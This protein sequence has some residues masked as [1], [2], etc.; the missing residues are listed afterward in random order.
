MSKDLSVNTGSIREK[1]KWS[2]SYNVKF[3][4]T[5]SNEIVSVSHT[6]KFM[7]ETSSPPMRSFSMIKKHLF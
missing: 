4:D 5:N 3:H 6:L 1:M 2:E 7:Q